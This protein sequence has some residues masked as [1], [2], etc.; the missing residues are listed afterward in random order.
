[1][2]VS[3]EDGSAISSTEPKETGAEH[4]L[5]VDELRR[6]GNWIELK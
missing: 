5:F 2:V 6:N 4:L 3:W 1:M